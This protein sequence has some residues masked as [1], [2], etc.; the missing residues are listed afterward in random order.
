MSRAKSFLKLHSLVCLMNRE[1]FFRFLTTKFK[2]LNFA[3]PKRCQVFSRLMTHDPWNLRIAM[4][5][6]S[7]NLSC[8]RG[9]RWVLW[10]AFTMFHLSF[11]NVLF[12]SFK[13]L[14]KLWWKRNS[15][16]ESYR[17]KLSEA[18]FPQDCRGLFCISKQLHFCL[19]CAIDKTEWRRR[20]SLLCISRSPNCT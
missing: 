1:D 15:A 19:N 4:T 12:Y 9:L 2:S 11:N 3:A 13:K 18:K 17:A 16:F 6:V 8:C 14:R 10:S 7:S 20:I 5:T